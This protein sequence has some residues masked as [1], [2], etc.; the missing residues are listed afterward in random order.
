MSLQLAPTTLGV[1]MRYVAKVHR[2]LP[3]VQGG[4]FAVAVKDDDELVGV[5]IVGRPTARRGDDGWT[6]EVVRV[7]VAEGHPNACSMLYGAARRAAKA[8]GYRRLWTYTL[9]HEPGTS[10][11]AAGWRLDTKTKGGP[12]SRVNRP[13]PDLGDLGVKLRWS[14]QLAPEVRA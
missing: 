2:H 11:L 6:A 10:L 14:A 8:L 13:R 5:A 7:A 3:H 4:L 9:H 1:A 12:W